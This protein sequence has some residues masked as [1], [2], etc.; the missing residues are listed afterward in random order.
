MAR[1]SVNLIMLF[2]ATACLTGCGTAFDAPSRQF[3][4]ESSDETLSWWRSSDRTAEYAAI[5][6]PAEIVVAIAAPV[7]P[8]PPQDIYERLR[9]GF[10]IP[11]LNTA[12]V[13]QREL[14][15]AQR[16]DLVRRVFDRSQ[17]YLYHI[18]EELE[19]RNMP[20]ELALLPFIESGFDP[21]AT[22]SAQAAG[23]WQFIPNTATRY[24]LR[25]DSSRDERR[26]IIASTTAALDYL[27]FLY[28]TFGNW[29]LALASYN[30]GENAV[31]RAVDKNRTL[32]LSASY[33]HL[34]M[35][36]ETQ[37]YVPKLQAIKNIVANQAV[38]G[39]LLP[40]A[41][42][43]PYF[44]VTSKT[45]E[46]K[47]ADAARYAGMQVDEFVSLNTGYVNTIPREQRIV[48]PLEKLS[49]FELKS[50]EARRLVSRKVR[51]Q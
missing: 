24:N 29:Q 6:K 43:R 42:N 5:T 51:T 45:F 35:P 32:K 16:P 7:A 8:P 48:L 28:K 39:N 41:P 50:D 15:F 37:D 21:R 1:L 27:E 31:Q 20:T 13:R 11:D 2:F 10:A 18:V 25:I 17:P 14:W 4:A 47:I 23:I 26:D 44:V 9:R 12:R 49:Q 30:W 22:S 33:E 36:E 46:L 38:Y 34:T 19:K 40:R 3:R